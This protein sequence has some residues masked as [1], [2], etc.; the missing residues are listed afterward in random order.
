MNTVMNGKPT[1]SERFSGTVKW[2]NPEKGYGFIERSAGQ[3]KDIF[4]HK[5]SL[6]EGIETLVEGQTITYQTE[7]SRK[8]LRAVNIEVRK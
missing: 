6:P 8:G 2:F 7:I 5:N 3:D 1:T 4:V